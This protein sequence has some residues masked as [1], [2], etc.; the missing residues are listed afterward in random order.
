MAAKKA[1]KCNCVNEVNEKLKDIGS[2][3]KLVQHMEFDFKA[4]K[5]SMSG[6]CIE[7]CKINKASRKKLPTVMCSYCPFCGIKLG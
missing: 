1:T 7:V 3:A 5:A 6:P 4:G 2:G